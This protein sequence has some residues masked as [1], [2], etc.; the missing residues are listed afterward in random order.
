VGFFAGLAPFA[1]VV[2]VAGLLLVLL[3]PIRALEITLVAFTLGLDAFPLVI[4]FLE[5]VTLTLLVFPAILA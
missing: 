1:A 4:C 3:P 5:A 2:L